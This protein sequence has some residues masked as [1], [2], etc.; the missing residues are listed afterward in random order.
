MRRISHRPL[1]IAFVLM[2]CAIYVPNMFWPRAALYTGLLSPQRLR[3]VGWIGKLLCLAIG[4]YYGVQSARSF[5]KKDASRL[6]WLIAGAWLALWTIGYLCIGTYVF[7]LHQ[8]LP[9]PEAGDLA[10]LLGYL[11][12]FV[13]Q[14]RF[15]FVY[16]SSGLPVGSA[17]EHWLL[18]GGTALVA[19]VVS[20]FLLAPI[21]RSPLSLGERFINVA[22]PSLDL[23]AL[24]PTV[25]MI[26]IALAFRPGRVWTVWATLLLS[27]LLSAVA[28]SID[29][30]L[31]PSEEAASTDPTAHLLWLL[32]YFFAACGTKL[33][34][35]LVT[36]P[37]DRLSA[38]PALV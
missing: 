9:C 20:Y 22:Y 18:G 37:A 11:L 28:D 31:W 10:F 16:R 4:S 7:A 32:S 19:L 27:F 26:R 1:V 33:Q 34:Y 13:A 35:E 5:G 8:P 29:S 6:P 15:I 24:A 2:A 23:L 14:F 30:Y 25:V 3:F 12:V 36:E 38:A 21:A 17:R